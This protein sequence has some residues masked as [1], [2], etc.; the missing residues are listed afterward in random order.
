[1]ISFKSTGAV[2]SLSSLFQYP[3]ADIMSSQPVDLSTSII[4]IVVTASQGLHDASVVSSYSCP[5]SLQ[6]IFRAQSHENIPGG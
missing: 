3:I 1:M 4:I 6:G 2:L 5:D